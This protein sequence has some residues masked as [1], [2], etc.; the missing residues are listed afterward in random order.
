MPKIVEVAGRVFE[1]RRGGRNRV[2]CT[3]LLAGGARRSIDYV[4]QLTTDVLPTLQA[5]VE[6]LLPTPVSAPC[7]DPTQHGFRFYHNGSCGGPCPE[8]AT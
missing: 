4:E 3:E 1:F 7:I 2:Y 5:V 8:F 6:E